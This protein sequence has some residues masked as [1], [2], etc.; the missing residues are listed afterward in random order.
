M[1]FGKK[2]LLT[3]HQLVHTQIK[4][5]RS[6]SKISQCCAQAFMVSGFLIL[7]VPTFADEM[8]E[9][10]VQVHSFHI[11]AGDLASSLNQFAQ[12]VGITVLY[13]PEQVNNLKSQGLNSDY[14]IELGLEQLLTGTGLV[15][16]KGENGFILSPI[17]NDEVLLP[18]ID[19]VGEE[20][21][22]ATSPVDGYVAQRSSTATKSDISILETA[23]N[24]SV[25]S[26]EQIADRKSI[27]VENA[28][29]Y[30]S[31][32]KIAE[33]GLDPRFDQIS[34][35]GFSSTTNADFLDGLRQPNTGWLSYYSSEPYNLERVEILKGPA[36]VLYGYVSP[37]GMVNRVSKRPT[38]QEH[39]EVE[40]QAGNN[41]NIQTQFDVGGVLS[42]D[43]SVSYRVVGLARDADTDIQWV[44]NDAR[45]IAPSLNWQI[46]RDTN[47]T[48]LS[49]Y[50]DRQTS[51]SP[52]PYQQG[53]SL[54]KFW[55]GD[56]NFDKLDQQ[57]FTLG[58]EFEHNVNDVVSFQQNV[59]F[60]DVDT[61]NQYTGVDSNVDGHTLSRTAY[62]VYEEMQSLAMDNRIALSFDVGKTQHKLVTGVDYLHIDS[63]VLYTYG[64]APSIDMW[65][66][67]YRQSISKPSDLIVDYSYDSDL[68]GLYV[69]DQMTINNW[70][71]SAGLRR[72]HSKQI[73]K[74]H[75]FDS[76]TKRTESKTTGQIGALYLFESGFA[77]YA[78]FATSFVPTSGT[79]LYGEAYKPTEGEQFELGIKYQ[80][81]GT[82]HMITA[83]VY[84]LTQSNVLT[85]DPANSMN[86]IQTGEQEAL[87]FEVEGSFDFNEA[88]KLVASYSYNDAEVTKSN[89]GNEGNVP[90]NTPKH[91][92]SVWG[93]YTFEDGMLSGIGIGSGVRWVGRSYGSDSNTQKNSDYAIA[94]LALH[95]DLTGS[96]AGVRIGL[97]ATNLFDNRYINC[98]SG[99]CYRGEGRTVVGSVRY[100]W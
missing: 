38:G 81:P 43:E 9:S 39:K 30:T 93:D 56:E 59:R 97:N 19:V 29:S 3:K 95:Y 27:S 24:I 53:D 86:S 47:L 25:V 41:T 7:S 5:S 2:R 62:G 75:S 88:F 58:Y 71:L 70:R 34:I 15:A 11:K 73:L 83:S 13:T 20:Y 68:I 48:I 78:S 40:L 8:T 64:D 94:D 16:Q 12:Q 80:P 26:A 82:R 96:A 36:S 100:R 32:V 77:P 99:Y 51:G 72:D 84:H 85:R 79:N 31:G 42:N 65:A 1:A 10:S 17:S 21:E 74:D 98:E 4:P 44:N 66:P 54:T 18:I 6:F 46:N 49:S 87:G 14:S 91:L 55:A 28:V 61:I 33:S 76:K 60:G 23:R 90:G 50:Q 92:A 67:N 37:G 57:Q 52:R 22:S 35:R 89:D 45:V 69:Q 63:D